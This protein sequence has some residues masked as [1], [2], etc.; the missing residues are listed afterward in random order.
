MMDCFSEYCSRNFV[1][2][3]VGARWG[4][5]EPFKSYRD[6]VDV[7][8]FEPDQEE[9]EELSNKKMNRD[10]VLPYAL[11]SEE[12]IINLNL[13][14]ARGCS[15]IYKPNIS[16][17]NKFPD[18]ERFDVEETE[19]V[20]A[21]TFDTLFK[22]QIIQ[23]L[24]FIKLDTQGTELDILRGGEK[25][26]NDNIIGLQ[27]EVEFKQMY[28]GQPVFSEIDHY[29]RNKFELELFDIRK[30]CWKYIEGRGIGPSK[31]QLIFGDALYF[32]NPFELPNWCSQFGEEEAKN[33]V[34]M[35]CFM[36]MIYGYPD[37]SLCILERPELLQLVDEQ[38][39]REL[40]IY[41]SNLVRCKRFSFRGSGKIHNIFYMLSQLFKPDH[42]GWATGEKHLGSKKIIGIYY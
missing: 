36:G 33:K 22:H 41:I 30:A 38:V 31:G 21:T 16:F 13:T 32:R 15:S 20:Q 6:C 28:N 35:A 5:E 12:K 24:D 27:I 9:Y 2:C 19:E 7:I 1:F 26:I 10:L 18:V 34:I 42:E 14:K 4:L 29:I 23:Q 11:Y 3:D 17:L 40:K 25:L 8:S 39:I 37:Y